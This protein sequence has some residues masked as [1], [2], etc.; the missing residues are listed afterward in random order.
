MG[1]IVTIS[2]AAAACLWF[3]RN[4]EKEKTTKTDRAGWPLS[5]P[6][7]ILWSISDFSK[8]SSLYCL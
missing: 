4:R 1:V 7:K 2:A 5:R 3:L 6:N 8:N